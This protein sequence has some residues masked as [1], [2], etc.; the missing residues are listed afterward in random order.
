MPT[1][2]RRSLAAIAAGALLTALGG[3]GATSPLPA[4]AFTGRLLAQGE[5]SLVGRLLVASEALRDPRFARTVVF[6]VRHDDKGAMGLIVNRPVRDLPLAP[7]LRKFGLDDRG[8]TTTVRAHYGGPVE[9]RLGFVLHTAEYARPETERIAGDIALTSEEAVPE[10]LSDIAHG[11]GP[12]QSLFALGYAGW[13]PGQLEGEIERG[14]WIAVP[15]DPALVFDPDHT[16][17]WERAMAR[18]LTI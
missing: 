13:A 2:L 4:T 15:A 3:P 17:K 14:S 9:L 5:P 11:A 8:V 10:V 1:A 6:V 18:R 7:L 16:Q 12:R